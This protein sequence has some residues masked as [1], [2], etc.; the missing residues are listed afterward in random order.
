MWDSWGPP[1]L[2]TVVLNPY[3]ELLG[4]AYSLFLQ[5]FLIHLRWRSRG[6][7]GCGWGICRHTELMGQIFYGQVKWGKSAHWSGADL[8]YILDC[9]FNSKCTVW[10]VKSSSSP[11]QTASFE[12]LSGVVLTFKEDYVT[13]RHEVADENPIC[14]A[15]RHPHLN[16]RFVSDHIKH[17]HRWVQTPTAW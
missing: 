8:L 5:V 15:E 13:F 10:P 7:G 14:R 2:Q 11:I 1:E 12:S 9:R 17:V 4:A 6:H 16:G 3:D